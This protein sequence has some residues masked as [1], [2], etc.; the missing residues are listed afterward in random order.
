[1]SQPEEQK[2]LDMLELGYT[3]KGFKWVNGECVP[4]T[5]EEFTEYLNS[6]KEY[7]HDKL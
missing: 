1:V 6:K 4:M 7:Q 2:F 5:P 3:R